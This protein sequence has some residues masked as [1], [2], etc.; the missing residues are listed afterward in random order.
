VL[1]ADMTGRP[2]GNK[3]AWASTGDFATQRH[4]R[5]RQLGR[6][7]ATR[8]DDIVVERLCSGTTPLTTALQPLGLAAAQPLDLDE[9]TRRRTLWRLAAGGGRVEEVNGLLGRGYPVHCQDYAGTRAQTLAAGVTTWGN[10]P[11]LPE[12]QV[13][14]VPMAVTP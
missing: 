8:E 3:A 10:D 7:L 11:R 4:R 6:V 13:G 14:W 9:D 12:R 5:G 1:E 2:C